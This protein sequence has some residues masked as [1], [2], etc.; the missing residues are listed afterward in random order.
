MSM[1]RDIVFKHYIPVFLV[2][3]LVLMNYQVSIEKIHIGDFQS[4]DSIVY[5]PPYRFITEVYIY[6]PLT[7]RVEK[8]VYNGLPVHIEYYGSGYE[9][10]SIYSSG[11]DLYLILSSIIILIIYYF[12]F[13]ILFQR[14]IYI[15]FYIIL[16]LIGLSILIN[17]LYVLC[18]HEPISRASIIELNSPL[19][20]EEYNTTYICLIDIINSSS[21]IYV[22]TNTSIEIVVIRDNIL[23]RREIRGRY[24]N[25]IETD[26]ETRIGII[27]PRTNISLVYRR[28]AFENIRSPY[29]PF[30]YIIFSLSIIVANFV[31]IIKSRV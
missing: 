24:V 23:D 26:L 1:S 3:I 29:S 14:K 8:F 10:L 15:K 31:L 9:V 13:K 16:V 4:I 6:D 21:I 25:F 18:I 20:C 12:G 11:I 17:Y 19:N 30:Y 5:P 22:E 28:L 27:S 7:D 2:L